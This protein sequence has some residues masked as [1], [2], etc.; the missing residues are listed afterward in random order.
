MKTQNA[1]AHEDRLL[2]FAYDE[3]P[4]TEARAVEL[5]LQ[6]CSRCSETLRGIRGVRRSMA[7][8]PQEVEPSAGLDS[9]LA[10]AQ[11]SA[12]RAAAGAEPPPR[13]WRRLMAPALGMAAVSL[14]GVV[15]V[16]VDRE[17]D[18]SPSLQSAVQEPPSR[19]KES[20][21]GAAAP[22]PS[23]VPAQPPSE[24]LAEPTRVT[25]QRTE[26]APRASQRGVPLAAK[27]MP[28]P[29]VRGQAWEGRSSGLAGKGG[30]SSKKSY[31]VDSDD[32][33]LA[34]DEETI[35]GAPMPTV[36]IPPPAKQRDELEK[37]TLALVAPPPPPSAPATAASPAP[38][39]DASREPFVEEQKNEQKAESASKP[40]ARSASRASPSP[41]ELVR[42]ADLA[43]RAGDRSQEAVFLRAALAAGAQGTQALEA[44]SRLCDAESALGR[45]PSAV[46]VCKRVVATAPGSSQARSALRLLE[47]PLQSPGAGA[48]K[49]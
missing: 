10:Y 46:E 47:G 17:V 41:T 29:Q 11:Q 4:L 20:A 22:A 43:L 7:R 37:E 2:D 49:Q 6:G 14:F 42:Q 30:G 44:L 9:L 26:K 35:G 40:V 25:P 27:S 38:M 16:Q 19:A 13:W 8:L 31:A 34:G 48:E 18:L 23:S 3:L 1:H 32:S 5:H 45:R 24:A 39:M 15:V 36:S 21:V 28:S 33:A 12:R